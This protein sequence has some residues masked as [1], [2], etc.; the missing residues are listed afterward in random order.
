MA[1]TKKKKLAAPSL[2]RM[3]AGFLLLGISF[4]LVTAPLGAMVFN[5]HK[6]NQ[7]IDEHQQK[8]DALGPSI[9][10][11]ALDEAHA[12]N[13]RLYKNGSKA[14]GEATDPW[15]G[16]EN[17]ISSKDEEYQNLLRPPG[18]G[19]MATI[20]YPRLGINIPVRHGTSDAVLGAGAGHMYGTSL[21]VGGPNTHSVIA[22][23][24]GLA[25]RLLFDRLSLGEGQVG[26]KFA[27]LVMGQVLHYE[28][29]SIVEVEP[30]DFSGFAIEPGR[31]LVTLLTCTP[32][33]V[34]N[35][36]LLVTG[37]RVP[38]EEPPV[39]LPSKGLSSTQKVL[40]ITAIVAWCVFWLFVLL[41]LLLVWRPK[42]KKEQ[43]KGQVGTQKK[44]PQK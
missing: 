24:T 2:G 39:D 12:Y 28:V 5:E 7:A 13:D 25:S 9:T 43:A 40:I 32:Y 11:I 18:D 38:G 16:G 14:L 15:S 20:S 6:S 26:D 8:V 37:K 33:G 29:E 3:L 23:H 35:K 10:D 30:S 4:T 19:I 27:V 31:D 42:K 34:N 22:A 21:P 1:S 36:R 17:S 41:Y 44:P